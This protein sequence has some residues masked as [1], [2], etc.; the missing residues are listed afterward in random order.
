MYQPP[1]SLQDI[2]TQHAHGHQIQSFCKNEYLIKEILLRLGNVFFACPVE[3]QD[4][5]KY[6]EFLR[7]LI[8]YFEFVR[9][10]AQAAASMC[11]LHC[12]AHI[13]LQF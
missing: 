11:T 12:T 5:M 13:Q 7:F 1:N 9:A 2:A 4:F 8:S 3:E 10:V 6:L